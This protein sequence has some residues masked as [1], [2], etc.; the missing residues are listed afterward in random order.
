M[1]LL[2]IAKLL[3]IYLLVLFFLP[4]LFFFGTFA[5]ALR[6]SERPIAIAC[7][8]LV[9]FLPLRPLFKVPLFFSRITFSTFSL[10]FFEYFAIQI[11][12]SLINRKTELPILL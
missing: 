9:T 3:A 6:A 4:E 7:F 11:F 1:R 5:P 2:N 8:R 10:A 12:L